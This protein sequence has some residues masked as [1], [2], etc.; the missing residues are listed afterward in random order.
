[1]K[2]KI[3]LLLFVFLSVIRTYGQY[4]ECLTGYPAVKTEYTPIQFSFWPLTIFHHDTDVY[5]IRL[6]PGVV[7]LQGVVWGCSIGGFIATGTHYGLSLSL[8]QTGYESYGIVGVVVNVF[9]KNKG[10][11]I[12]IVNCCV[13]ENGSSENYLQIGA[14]NSARNGL[15]IGLLNYNPKA[16]IPW[17]PLFNY[18]SPWS[19]QEEICK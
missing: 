3:F 18:S 2:R 8:C 1:M 14:F 7:N 11:M 5:G 9:E 12:V 19:T 15:Q 13:P 10:V 17:M 16:F 4:S 6:A